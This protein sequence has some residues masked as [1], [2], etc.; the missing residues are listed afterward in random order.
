MDKSIVKAVKTFS[1]SVFPSWGGCMPKSLKT[2]VMSLA[3]T[4]CIAAPVMAEVPVPTLDRVKL[5]QTTFLDSAHSSYALTE[6]T[7]G[8]AAPEGSITVKI[9]DKTY[10]YTPSEN[11][12]VLKTLASTGSAA[13][14]ETTKD[15]ALYTVGGKYY[16]YNTE[17]L[18]DSGYSLKEATS[19]DEPNTI[20][21]YDKETVIKYYDPKTGEEVAAGDRQPDIEYREVQ[22]IQTTPKYY[23]VE[24]KQTEYGHAEVK[25]D[26]KTFTVTTPDAEGSGKAFEYTVN[27]YVDD[28]RL[29]NDRITTNQNGADIDK[30]FVGLKHEV[31]SGSAYGGA[32]YNSGTIGDITGDFIGNYASGSSSASGGAIYNS[33]ATIGNITGDFIGNYAI[34][35]NDYAYGGAIYNINSSTI[36]DITGD[37]IGNYASS[38]DYGASGGAIYNYGTIGDITGDFIGNYASGSSSASG[39]AIYN[40]G[41]IGD[42]TGDFIGNYVSSSSSSYYA[43]GGAIYNSSSTIGDIT[44]DF[45]GNYVSSSSSSSSSF[46]YY[47]SGGAIYNSSTIG[48]IT[49]DFIGNYVF[50][51][52]FSASGGAIYN[53]SSSSR[54][55][56]ITGDFIGNYASSSDSS[57]SGGAIDNNYNSTIG[58][59][60][61]DFIG[62]YASGSSAGGGAIS[63]SSSTI[64]DITGDFIGN[65]ASST[66]YRAYGGAIYNTGTIGN[67]TGDFIGNYASSTGYRAYGGAII[68]DGTIGDITGDFIGNYA[69]GSS[70]GGGAIY[71]GDDTIGIKDESGDVVGG[72]INSSF[73]NNYARATGENGEA[74]GGAIY[75][76]NSLNIIAK[77][78]GQSVFSGNYTETSGVKT[79]NAI[80][81]A[82]TVGSYNTTKIVSINESTV[83]TESAPVHTIPTL[84]LKPN[85]NGAIRFDDTIDGNLEIINKITTSYDLSVNSRYQ[86][87]YGVSTV[88]ELVEYIK[89]NPNNFS[90]YTED[91]TDVEILTYLY[92]RTSYLDKTNEQTISNIEHTIGYSLAITGDTTGKVILNN[93]VINANISLDNTNLYLGRENVF[94]RSQ[95]LTL[96]SGSIYLNNNTIGTMHIPTLNLKGNTNLSV[97]A[98]LATKT[99]DKI[100]AD[101]Y[102][103]TNNAMLNVNNI[104]LLSDA[105]EDKTNISF[106]DKDLANNV[107]YTGASPIAYSPIYKY[108]VSYHPETGEFMFL[109]GATTTPGGDII[110]PTN[111]SDAF[112]PSVLAPAVA[113]QAGAYTTQLQTFN[114]AFQHSDNFMNIPYLERVAIIEKNK[115]A[116]SPTGD[117]TD[118]GTFSPL[119]TK[120]EDAGFWIKP[121]ASFENIPLKN[122]P[123]VS[124]INY[125]TLIGYDSN[126]THI[127][128]GWERVL[129]G[130]VGYNGAS[131]RYSGVDAYQNG[132]LIGTTATFYKGN[133]FNATTLSVGASV[134]DATTMYG[135]ENY[136]MLLAGIGNKTGYNFEFKEGRIILQPNFLISYTFVNTFDYTNGAGVRIESDPLHA[137]QLAPGIK[138]IGNTKNGWQ[139]YIG[140]NMVWNLLDDSKVYANDIRLPEMSIKPYVQYG[141]GLQKRFKDRFLAFGQAMIHNGG[142]NGISF[143]FGLRWKVGK[144]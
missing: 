73:I 70:A 46:Y 101:T 111:P 33:N 57:A 23:T 86:T 8:T 119:L 42:I 102:N 130:Y 136:T 51:T 1:L 139:P 92:N 129:T 118:V 135:S 63:N 6:L 76:N 138:L 95:S 34:S 105:K 55:G 74:L 60:T 11:T 24:L 82:T 67:I 108:Q 121:Y 53:S 2:A 122:G 103:I 27:Y 81:I 143:S 19:A 87:R 75:T 21:L 4:L 112:N 71:N 38:T 142:R 100:T 91:M 104:T 140:V 18:K 43:S 128:N 64:G 94:D 124:N 13:L 15:K 125:G 132:G 65:Y 117:A 44:G 116:L 114:Y 126:L 77:D 59:I 96:N 61:G 110:P 39:G 80:Y 37:F 99:M 58:D 78:G 106:A 85:S 16:T 88:S 89:T 98:D 50:S 29:A 69:S 35:E 131:Q 72:L 115:Y 123:K 52:G 31:T 68:N 83:V 22:T 109:R 32:I 97:D 10:Y 41:T 20:T 7:D 30:D 26:T 45:I 141:V 36:G 137:I 93:D 62:N 107:A 14:V 134:G 48:D 28:D 84:T 25:D 120:E 144:D 49:G 3:L 133:F 127:K 12:E 17:K 79:P 56:N 9:A 90:W 113:T 54:I 40:R 47:A 66:G 5:E